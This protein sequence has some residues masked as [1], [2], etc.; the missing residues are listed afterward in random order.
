MKSTVLA[1]TSALV[2]ALLVACA[3]RT[4]SS[5]V[6]SF[7]RAVEKG[8]TDTAI[9]LITPELVGLVGENKIRAGLQDQGL[10]IKQK[11]GIS[12]IE[13]RDEAVVGEIATLT[14]VLTFGDGS[15]DTEKTKLRKMNGE[16]KIQPEK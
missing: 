13:I 2:L 8:D 14:A 16:W 15:S 5:A 9:S 1:S 6:K 3:G 12:A 4:P 7:Y 11:G 10:K